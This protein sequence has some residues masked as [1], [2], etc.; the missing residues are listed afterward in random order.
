MSM[1][2]RIGIRVAVT[3]TLA[4]V[5]ALAGREDR[6]FR[7]VLHG[8][9]WCALPL[10]FIATEAS[11]LPATRLVPKSRMLA[12]ML[13]P[14]LP[15]GG[16]GALFLL[17]HVAAAFAAVAASAGPVKVFQMAVTCLFAVIFVLLPC[18]LRPGLVETSRGRMALRLTSALAVGASFVVGG[19]GG[20]GAHDSWR[21]LAEQTT[22]PWVL[23]VMITWDDRY[24]GHPFARQI[25]AALAL[26]AVLGNAKRI[27]RGVVEVRDRSTELC[28]PIKAPA[29]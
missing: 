11:A 3:L 17:L 6:P 9:E 20:Y 12:V 26:I 2:L 18:A 14:W 23:G 28:C 21:A 8:L 19:I 29:R 10:L 27:V 13:S 1:L 16:R 5:I 22:S 24:V 15:G 7:T 4:A 25:V